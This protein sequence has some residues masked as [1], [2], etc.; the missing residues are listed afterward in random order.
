MIGFVVPWWL[1]GVLALGVV[2][3]VVAILQAITKI[4]FIIFTIVFI[5]IGLI[6]IVK[7]IGDGSDGYGVFH[8]IVEVVRGFFIMCTSLLVKYWLEIGEGAKHFNDAKFVL[9][10]TFDK[11]D[12]YL[13]A[14]FISV[15]LILILFLSMLPNYLRKKKS[16]FIWPILSLIVMC[17]LFVGAFKVSFD[18]EMNNTYDSIDWT[19][20]EYEAVNDISVFRDDIVRDK[21]IEIGTIKAGTK[22]FIKKSKVHEEPYDYVEVSDGKR[23]VY[24]KTAE[25]KSLVS[26]SYY[27]N[28]DSKLLEESTKEFFT[29]DD[30][31]SPVRSW[32]GDKVIKKVKKGEKVKKVEVCLA[33]EDLG[34]SH[35]LVEL[36]DGTRGYIFLENIT[37]IRK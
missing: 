24:V 5:V 34:G 30:D 28:S 8:S 17:V 6:V 4:A 13:A 15:I 18:S 29:W 20:P 36:S 2:G 27:V 14:I 31:I 9:L 11:V 32:P 1:I 26:Y 12:S 25:V 35:M 23:V 22:L 33:P 16:K 19:S 3:G 7:G 21:Y 10:G 37:E